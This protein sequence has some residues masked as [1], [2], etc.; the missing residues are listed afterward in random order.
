MPPLWFGWGVF[1]HLLQYGRRYDHVHTASFSY[2]S[3]LAA[4]LF[5]PFMRYSLGVDWHEVWSR[6]YWRSYLGMTGPFG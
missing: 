6:A 2:F 4:G 1:W 5:K 3:L